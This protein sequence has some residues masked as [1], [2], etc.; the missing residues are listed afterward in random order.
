MTV[1]ALGRLFD[2][3]LGINLIA[4]LAAGN[5]TGKRIN[6][7]NYAGVAG[8]VWMNA[9]S[10]GTD[11]FVPDWQQHTANTGGTSSDL[12]VVTE[13]Y[14][15][16]ATTLAGTEA[17]TRVTQ[18]IASEISLTGA[19]YAANQVIMVS[20][21]DANSLSDGYTHVSIDIADP[22]TG[23]T[24]LGGVLYIPFGLAVQRRPDALAQPNAA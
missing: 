7:K 15:K 4:D 20:E 3:A 24:R 12:D 22:G 8:V 13:W 1:K 17:W 10:A 6:V 19:T 16:N 11:T 21:I 14:I 5:N 2:V 9:V 23:G 18:S